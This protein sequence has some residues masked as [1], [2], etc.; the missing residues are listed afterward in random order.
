MAA[1]GVSQSLVLHVGA[2]MAA[3]RRQ[4]EAFA[5]RRSGH[6]RDPASADPRN[7]VLP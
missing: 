1:I 7:G 3:I 5:P 2:A 6:G 4:P